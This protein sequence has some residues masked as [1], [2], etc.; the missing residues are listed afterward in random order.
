M[1]PVS[2]HAHS[3]LQYIAAHPRAQ[4]V[5][6][7]NAMQGHYDLTLSRYML[8]YLTQA[9]LLTVSSDRYQLTPQGT[10]TLQQSVDKHKR[11]TK[12]IIYECG[13]LL[14]AAV[15][16]GFFAALFPLVIK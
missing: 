11:S 2:E 13:K 7:I 8:H 1:I 9:K 4:E 15:A 10:E 12:Q 16:G 6:I 5:D 14:L 3:I